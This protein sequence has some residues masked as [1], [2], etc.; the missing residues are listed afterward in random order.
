MSAARTIRGVWWFP[1]NPSQR[2]VGRL[3]IL[4]GE[5]PELEFIV[6]QGLGFEAPAFPI[7]LFGEDEDGKSI[8]LVRLGRNNLSSTFRLSEATYSAG[9]AF[10]GLHVDNLDTLRITEFNVHIQQLFGWICRTGFQGSV[11]QSPNEEGNV[12]FRRPPDLAF[13]V[14]D[15]VALEVLSSFTAWDKDR[16]QGVRED[17]LLCF[18]ASKDFGFHEI[19]SLINSLREILHFATLTPI[20]PIKVT[21]RSSDT[22][23]KRFEWISGWLHEYVKPELDPGYWI[24]RFSDVQ[25]NFGSFLSQWFQTSRFQREALGCYFTT[26]Y[27]PLPDSVVH[28]CLTQALEAYHGIRTSTHHRDFELKIRELAEEHGSSL[29]G[30]FDNPSDFAITVRHNRNYYTHHNPKWLSQGRVAKDD[31]L[32]RLNEKLRLLFQACMLH[33]MGIPV[34]R[35]RRLCRQLATHI[36]NYF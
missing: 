2:W 23:S 24:F 36:V 3:T 6:P 20:Y 16:E 33:E 7:A 21:G 19:R 5:S 13:S 8:S 4:P 28:L 26:V 34:E 17:V 11:I 9:H 22:T 25:A 27:H 30:L 14:N 32:Y 35:C 31:E 15:G 12:Q 29:P 18:T 10:L 1:N